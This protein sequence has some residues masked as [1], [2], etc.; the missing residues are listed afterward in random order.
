LRALPLSAQPGLQPAR[1]GHRPTAACRQSPGVLR[2]R[3]CLCGGSRRGKAGSEGSNKA[4]RERA[5]AERF[6]C[7]KLLV[8]KSGVIWCMSA[9]NRTSLPLRATSRT[10]SS[11]IDAPVRLCVRGAG[12]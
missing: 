11:P 5:S 10:P 3:N 2:D 1:P 4:P 9:V 6:R 12:S 8:S 7:M